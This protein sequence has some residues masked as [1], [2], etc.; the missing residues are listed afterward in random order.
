MEPVEGPVTRYIIY[1]Y[2][3]QVFKGVDDQYYV[4]FRGSHESI[5]LGTEP[6]DIKA[7]DRVEITIKKVINAKS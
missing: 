7:G 5:A 4:H 1:S 2:V 3:E 6:L